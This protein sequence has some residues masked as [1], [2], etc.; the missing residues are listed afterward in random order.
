MGESRPRRSIPIVIGIVAAVVVIAVVVGLLV[1]R[2]G[3]ETKTFSAQ[4]ISFDYP[5][6]WG[7]ITGQQFSSQTGTEVFGKNFGIDGS[8]AA[9][10]SIYEIN[11]PIDAS[12]I[13]QYRGEIDSTVA[14]LENESGGGVLRGSVTITM[15]SLPG[16]RYE[17]EGMTPDGTEVQ[18]RLVLVF[19]GTTEYFLN[20]QHTDEHA[21]EIEAGCDQIVESFAVK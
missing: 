5:G 20:C 12:N 21:E 17:V 8:N 19:D 4:G 11:V 9:I 13:E 15:G 18:S 14:G 3:E 16:Y 6:D 2:G 10:F 1:F 7:D